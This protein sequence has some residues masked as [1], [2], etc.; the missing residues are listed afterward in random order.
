M[1]PEIETGPHNSVLF[2]RAGNQPSINR[3]PV[4]ELRGWTA[5]T[6]QQLPAVDLICVYQLGETSVNKRAKQA[7]GRLTP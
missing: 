1:L 5:E 3:W 7:V 4:G 2:V 6:P